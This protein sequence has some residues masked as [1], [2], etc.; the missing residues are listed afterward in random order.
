MEWKI[1][2]KNGG[3]NL[4][5][6]YDAFSLDVFGVDSFFNLKMSQ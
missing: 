1:H 4:H 5:E 6:V 3:E 2:A